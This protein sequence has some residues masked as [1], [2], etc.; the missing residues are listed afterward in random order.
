MARRVPPG[1]D[2]DGYAAIA[3][4]LSSENFTHATLVLAQQGE[5]P[6]DATV[7]IV[8]GPTTDFLAPEI[9]I[10]K[11]YLARGG[12]VFFLLDPQS[13]AEVPD[14]PNLVALIKEWGIDPGNNIVLDA[15]GVGQML[16]TGPEVPIAA[17]Y[18]P[19]PITENF[20]VLTAY[21]LARTVTA[22]PGGGKQSVRSEP[23]RDRRQAWGETDI[24]ALM[25]SGQVGQDDKD[26]KG[27]VSLGAAVSAADQRAG[28]RRGDRR[29]PQKRRNLRR[30]WS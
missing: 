16:G 19:H 22:N 26:V 20:N 25:T 1:T 21:S 23:G 2:R 12:K 29:R 7:L 27:P 17:K 11:A 28:R 18:N 9:E 14:F 15:S 24:K 30:A 13:K 3:A 10:L 4:A 5:V 6:A 8:A